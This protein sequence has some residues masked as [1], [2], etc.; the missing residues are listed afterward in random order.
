MELVEFNAESGDALVWEGMQRTLRRF[1]QAA[2]VMELHLQR[3]PPQTMSL[4]HQIERAGYALR[5]IGY[6][7]DIVSTDAATIPSQQQ[8][9]WALWLRR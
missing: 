2:V 5:T 4:L 8:E 9:H 6:E 7:G 1:P 3:D